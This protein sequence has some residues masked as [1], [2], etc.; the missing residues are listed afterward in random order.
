MNNNM[1]NLN[2]NRIDIHC[3]KCN[4]CDS[5]QIIDVITEKEVFCHNCK[6]KIKLIDESAS[7]TNSIDAIHMKLFN[8][9]NTLKK[10]NK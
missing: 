7:V 9:N 10:F 8:L 4:Y 5:V 2:L 1:I 3:P 6:V